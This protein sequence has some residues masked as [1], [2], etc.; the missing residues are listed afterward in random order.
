MSSRSKE[1]D[2]LQRRLPPKNAAFATIGATV[3]SGPST[4]HAPPAYSQRGVALA[5][6]E[7]FGRLRPLQLR[8]LLS[9]QMAQQPQEESIFQASGHEG[10]RL[11]SVPAEQQRSPGAGGS[12][13]SASASASAQQQQQQ[14]AAAPAAEVLLLDVRPSEDAEAF[15]AV[16]ISGALYVPIQSYM[17]RDVLPA[18]M[19]AARRAVPQPVI[20]VYDEGLSGGGRETDAIAVASK[21]VQAGR[22]DAVMVVHGGLTARA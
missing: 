20:V 13:S 6:A 7:I 17:F 3:N 5:R 8:S 21:L 18:A 12:S 2:I 22:F 15:S 9:S 14:P 11:V 16:R 1:R 19:H 10:P 4:L